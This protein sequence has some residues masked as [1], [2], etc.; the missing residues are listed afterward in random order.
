MNLFSFLSEGLRARGRAQPP[1]R[2][3]SAHSCA[4]LAVEQKTG[5]IDSIL[6]A[7]QTDIVLEHRL[8]GRRIV[9]DTK[10][11]SVQTSS[12]FRE[13]VLKSGYLYQIYAYLR[14]QEGDGDPLSGYAAGWAASAVPLNRDRAAAPAGPP[15]EVAQ[16]LLTGTG[17]AG[18]RSPSHGLAALEDDVVDTLGLVLLEAPLH[19]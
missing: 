13:G 15:D 17:A 14:W 18:M 4:L 19:A 9:I 16:V 7:M 6:P 1:L 11:T 12:R 5:R 8:A 10:F 2:A 3:A